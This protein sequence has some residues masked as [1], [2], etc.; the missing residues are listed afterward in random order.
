MSNIFTYFLHLLIGYKKIGLIKDL[1]N[2]GSC[3]A[4]IGFQIMT[5][6][7]S[8]LAAINLENSSFI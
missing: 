7:D 5:G 8:H 4:P 3:N 2:F 1:M 6:I